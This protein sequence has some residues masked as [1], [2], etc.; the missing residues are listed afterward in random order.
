[1]GK[2][3][4]PSS[5]FSAGG[6]KATKSCAVLQMKAKN[7]NPY[8]CSGK[9]SLLLLGRGVFFFWYH[10]E[11]PK[12]QFSMGSWVYLLASLS[13]LWAK[14]VEAQVC[15]TCSRVVQVY[16]TVNM[17]HA[18]S[19][20]LISVWMF[21]RGNYFCDRS[22]KVSISFH[23]GRDMKEQLCQNLMGV[24]TRQPRLPAM[25]GVD[26]CSPHDWSMSLGAF[27]AKLTCSHRD[28]PG[29]SK[30]ASLSPMTCCLVN[31]SR[32]CHLPLRMTIAWRKFF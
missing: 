13:D 28:P 32:V 10:K 30:V 6:C 1:M 4:V 17:L 25:R 29:S 9:E 11:W 12:S 23:L 8:L 16:L 15:A 31:T 7:G 2:S 14:A 5:H 18:T 21:S 20:E 3:W 27:S 19:Q 24:Q 26:Q 22:Y